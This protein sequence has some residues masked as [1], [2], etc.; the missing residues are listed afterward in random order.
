LALRGLFRYCSE[1]ACLEGSGARRAAESSLKE[2]AAGSSSTP[3]R[4]LKEENRTTRA[5]WSRFLRVICPRQA[6][7][8]SGTRTGLPDINRRQ[9]IAASSS[10]GF[11]PEL[12]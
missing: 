9:A 7:A 6:S 3:N 11:R 1:Y 10:D 12:G 2:S 4:G 8:E 5:R